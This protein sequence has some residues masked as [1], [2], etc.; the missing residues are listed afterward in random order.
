MSRK[1]V[2]PCWTRD[3]RGR[4]IID[5]RV[6]PAPPSVAGFQPGLLRL[7]VEAGGRVRL[8]CWDAEGQRH[9]TVWIAGRRQWRPWRRSDPRVYRLFRTE[10]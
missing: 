1:T 3:A 6:Y 4:V 7:T 2:N 8:H 9:S 10:P 5:G